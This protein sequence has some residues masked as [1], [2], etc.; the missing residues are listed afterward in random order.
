MNGK[1]KIMALGIS[2]FFLIIG[3]V[4]ADELPS[5]NSKPLS[6]LV[7]SLE[8]QKLGIVTSIEFDDGLWEIEIYKA[9]AETKLFLDPVSGE[10]KHQ[11]PDD[12][13]GELPPEEGKPLSTIIE[14]LEKQNL[15]TIT[16]VEFD[17]GLWDVE[18][19][20]DGAETELRID[21]KSGDSLR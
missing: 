10:I 6:T 11:F 8:E 18:I 7:R 12:G 2:L 4:Y 1:K 3:I 20:K 21:P 5:A 19:Q 15:G 13:D 17:D 16:N 9:G 14:S